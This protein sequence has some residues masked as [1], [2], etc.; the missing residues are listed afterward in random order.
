[1]TIEGDDSTSIDLTPEDKE[2]EDRVSIS[3]AVP[4][5]PVVLNPLEALA[6]QRFIDL[7]RE[8]PTWLLLIEREGRVGQFIARRFSNFLTWK[9]GYPFWK[10]CLE[11][12]FEITLFT[13]AA[14]AS[15]AFNMWLWRR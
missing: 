8:A 2:D 4:A 13:V 11:Y 15:V 6:R 1:M 14:A 10:I 12:W 5:P 3:V 9:S 7:P